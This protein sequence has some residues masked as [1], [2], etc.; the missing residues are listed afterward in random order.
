MAFKA[1]N[2][3]ALD[4]KKVKGKPHTGT[5]N[6]ATEIVTKIG[7]QFVHNF[8]DDLGLPFGIYGFTMLNRALAGV[9]AGTLVRITY[10]G[11][12]NCQT[13]FGMKD[14]HQVLVEADDGTE[15]VA[16]EPENTKPEEVSF[17]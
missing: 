3:N 1:V 2:T 11:T 16:Q 7:K 13:K 5:Y 6:G 4:I 12:V 10:T 14:V 15:G 8:T 17:P 9:K